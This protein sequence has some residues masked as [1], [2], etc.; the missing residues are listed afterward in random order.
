M[1]FHSKFDGI[2]FSHGHYDDPKCHYVRERSG[3]DRYKFSIPV[4]GCGTASQQDYLSKDID[5][6]I[7]N[8]LIVQEDPFIQGMHDLA[9]NVRCTWRHTFSKVVTARPMSFNVCIL[10]YLSFGPIL[11]F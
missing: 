10:N 1:S 8:T 9:R 5:K 6:Y 4:H 3:R 2:I 11:Y 7:E